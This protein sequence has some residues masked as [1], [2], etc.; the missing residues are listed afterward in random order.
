MTRAREP[1]FNIPAVVLAVAAALAGIHAA[2]GLLT[3]DADFAWLVDFAFVPAREISWFAPGILKGLVER[4]PAGL[5]EN[6]IAQYQLARYL[7]AQGAHPWTVLTYAG[8]HEGWLHLGLNLLVLSA[9]GTPVARRFGPS[10]FLVLLVAGAVAGALMHLGVHPAGVAPLI[11]ASASVSACMGAAARF[12]FDPMARLGGGA[13]SLAA[14]LRNRTV[15]AFTLGWFIA[16]AMSGLG[17][18]PSVLAN[19]SIA[20]EAHIGG[21]LLG[22]LAFAAFDPVRR[23]TETD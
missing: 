22:F 17:A 11:G 3:E 6:S 21:F 7:L 12:V 19:A 5:D 8:L 16:N 18:N 20:W 2:R 9:L 13:P 4:G 15:I 14:S 10:R 1:I 23:R